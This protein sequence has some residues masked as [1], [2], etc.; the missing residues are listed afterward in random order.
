MANL[1]RPAA[2]HGRQRLSAA[3]QVRRLGPHRCVAGA[4]S[5]L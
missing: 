2:H 4:R 3:A 1:P 5:G